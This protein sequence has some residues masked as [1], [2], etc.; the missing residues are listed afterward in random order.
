MLRRTHVAIGIGAALYF[1][2][3]VTHHFLFVFMAFF[4]SLLPDVDSMHSRLGRN[5]VFR[6]VQFATKHRG[7]FHS[8]TLC[9]AFSFVLALMWP[10]LAFGFFLGYALHLIADSFTPQGIRPF[11]PMSW[12][13]RGPIITGSLAEKVVFAMTLIVDCA[14]VLRDYFGIFS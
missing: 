4:G 1:F 11:W 10:L 14:L 3:F 9:L 8:F 12:D 5:I 2:P 7:I 13:S 6:P